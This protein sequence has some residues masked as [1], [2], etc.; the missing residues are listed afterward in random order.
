LGLPPRSTITPKAL[1]KVIWAGANNSSYPL[2]ASALRE[3]AELS[4]SAKQIRRWINE[5][6]EARVAEREQAVQ[7][8]RAMPLPARRAGNPAAA[9]P[10]LAVI[11]M[12]GGRYQRR[13]N[14]R[15]EPLREPGGTHWREDKVGCLLSMA[16]EVQAEDPHPEFPA[17]LASSA[18]VAELANLA[19][20]QVLSA[21]SREAPEA[22]SLEAASPEESDSYEPPE[23]LA[24]E[25]LASGVEMESFGWQLE[26]RAWR[27]GFPAA[28]RQAYVA[29]GAAANWKLQRRHFPR[30][31]PILDL[32]HALSYAWSAA[33]AVDQG[34]SYPRWA[35]WIWQGQVA[36]VLAA[37]AEHCAALGPP[38]PDAQ[39]SDP[40]QRV[41]RAW[42]YYVHHA[43]RMNYPQ[44]RQQGLPLTSSHIESTIKQINQRIKGSEKFWRRESA[45]AV[46]QLRADSLS[47]SRPL[48]D[49]WPR[50]LKNNTGSNR[51]QTA[52]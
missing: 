15:S 10:E 11:L 6:G 1:Q 43:A 28:P 16:S 19:E 25:V 45:E 50:W 2:A 49:F 31:T 20:S 27:L 42:T 39:A 7:E 21:S 41:Q 17:W 24:R 26:A 33:A 30:A 40:R 8:L 47:D 3:L 35:A 22:A 18:A 34:A 44:Y 12:D 38:P 9:P 36:Q 51:Y 13:D 32:M 48:Q 29:D 52:A 5:I 23:L 4:L 46:L 37:L 14:F